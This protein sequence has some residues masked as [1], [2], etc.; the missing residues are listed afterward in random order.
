MNLAVRKSN[1]VSANTESLHVDLYLYK[2]EDTVPTVAT[3]N[4]VKNSYAAGVAEVLSMNISPY[5]R[6]FIHH[7]LLTMT[8]NHMVDTSSMVMAKVVINGGAP[9]TYSCYDG[10]EEVGDCLSCDSDKSL[11]LG[12][13]QVITSV[14]GVASFYWFT[15]NGQSLTEPSNYDVYNRPYL[16]KAEPAGLNTDNA[17]WIEISGIDFEYAEVW[18]TRFYITPCPYDS[19]SY[20]FVNKFGVWETFTATG[21]RR[22]SINTTRES[23]KQ[24]ST[25]FDK[26]YFVNG[27]RSFVDNTGYVSNTFSA[28]MEDFYLSEETKLYRG[29]K[30][31]DRGIII[32]SSTLDVK[33]T[34]VDKLKNYTFS[35]KYVNKIIP[36]I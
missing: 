34:M 13:P 5:I 1:Y 31:A 29:S 24:L 6:D 7:D 4:L 9:T 3:Y 36:I 18:K 22:E 27:E 19:N 15:S 21:T 12:T 10:Y 33:H 2:P 28:E 20:A 30:E 16:V 11:V 8:G 26:Q 35:Y 32:T 23:Y 25:S 17:K 14:P